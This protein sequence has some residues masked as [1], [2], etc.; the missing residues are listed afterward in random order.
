MSKVGL[1]Q[2][3]GALQE[4]GLNLVKR[5]LQ[6]PGVLTLIHQ[7]LGPC[8]GEQRVAHG[9][10]QARG[11]AQKHQPVR[12]F[13]RSPNRGQTVGTI[14]LGRVKT[15]TNADRLSL[16][17]KMR[18]AAKHR[19][20]RKAIDHEGV[21]GPFDPLLRQQGVQ[22]DGLAGL[23]GLGAKVGPDLGPVGWTQQPAFSGMAGPKKQP[24]R[25]AFSDQGFAGPPALGPFLPGGQPTQVGID[26]QGVGHTEFAPEMGGAHAIPKTHM[27]H[28]LRRV[29]S[30]EQGTGVG[31]IFHHG[32]GGRQHET[33]QVRQ[34]GTQA[35][36]A[37]EGKR[38][39]RKPRQVCMTRGR[40]LAMASHWAQGR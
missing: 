7:Q 32:Q 14:A 3:T 27:N 28:A 16:G 10:L 34:T 23:L 18:R 39:R 38:Q 21:G 20:H 8:L 2:R 40:S 12:L 11:H 4:V 24:F 15:H 37:S 31:E 17:Q 9:G 35:R 26:E 5:L 30:G 19:Q 36:R 33:P 29:Q 22:P 13:K 25:F 1:F 6:P